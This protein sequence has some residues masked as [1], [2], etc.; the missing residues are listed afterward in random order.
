MALYA[1]T[2]N[3]KDAHV[4]AGA[5]GKGTSIVVETDLS[6]L[7]EKTDQSSMPVFSLSDAGTVIVRG[8]RNINRTVA[9]FSY[10]D[11]ETCTVYF[12]SQTEVAATLWHYGR[13]LLPK[14]TIAFCTDASTLPVCK[15]LGIASTPEE[16]CELAD[17]LGLV[18]ST[19]SARRI[20]D[21]EIAC[22][23]P[24]AESIDPYT[25]ADSAKTADDGTA[26]KAL[27][28]TSQ[29]KDV[30]AATTAVDARGLKIA[31]DDLNAF[32]SAVTEAYRDLA[33]AYYLDGSVHPEITVRKDMLNISV[34]VRRI[35]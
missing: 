34:P 29:A 30:R 6:E 2:V 10:I 1:I 26:R 35:R 19:R 15:R 32:E 13:E 14:S 20:M 5:P 16:F 25:R 23:D 3:A 7:S 33:D 28:G 18:L 9:E 21:G 27:R 31:P 17:D 8:P 12:G 24:L 11:R 4:Q 22:L